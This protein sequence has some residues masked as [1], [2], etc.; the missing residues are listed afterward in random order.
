[1]RIFALAPVRRAH[2]LR[3]AAA[4]AL[5]VGYADLVRGGITVAPALIVLAYVVLLPAVILWR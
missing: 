3:I 1:V 4:A 2:L 5:L